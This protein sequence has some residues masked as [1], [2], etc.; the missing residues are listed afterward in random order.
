M[1][2]ATRALAAGPGPLECRIGIGTGPVVAGAVGASGR[3]SYTVYGDSVNLAAR[4]EAL[5][6]DLGTAVLLCGET[7]AG[8]GDLPLKPAGTVTVRGQSTPTRLYTR[9]RRTRARGARGRERR[10]RPRS[11]APIPAG[12]GDR[13]VREPAERRRRR[14]GCGPPALPLRGGPIAHEPPPPR[15]SGPCRGPPTAH[16]RGGIHDSTCSP[17][18]CISS[19]TARAVGTEMRPRRAPVGIPPVIP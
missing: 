6:R 17:G 4:L 19:C 2:T 16:P 1:R 8:A 11:G 5:N 10:E 9:G 18:S 12:P 3:L 7:A 13:Q 15:A 14:R